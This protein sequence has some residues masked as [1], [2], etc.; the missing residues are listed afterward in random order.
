MLKLKSLLLIIEATKLTNTSE[1]KRWFKNSKVVDKNGNPLVM[2]HGTP[3]PG[4]TKFKVTSNYGGEHG[5]GAYFTSNPDMALSNEEGSAI[6]A[7][8]LSI[9]NPSYDLNT[10]AAE[11]PEET[12]L[13]TLHKAVAKGHD[14]VI[15]KKPNG[16][17]VVA[18][19]PHQIKSA[20]ANNG[21][22]DINDND[23]TK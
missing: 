7:C 12:Y 20:V 1:F 17:E 11:G 21:K 14:G 23:I 8:F 2:Y 22:F 19:Y 18:F 9:Q 13:Q 4:F 10:S 16:L 6:Y 5:T 3:S 15:I